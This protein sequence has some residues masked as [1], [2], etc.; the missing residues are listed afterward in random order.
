MR[1]IEI[2]V[3]RSTVQIWEGGQLVY[4]RRFYLLGE[5]Y[6]ASAMGGFVI[7]KLRDIKDIPSQLSRRIL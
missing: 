3:D 2:L 4:W 5:N 6:L 1:R 7:R